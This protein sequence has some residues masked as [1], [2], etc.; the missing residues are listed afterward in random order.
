MTSA[1]EGGQPTVELTI[2]IQYPLPELLPEYA[3]LGIHST[4]QL[5]AHEI[6]EM[7]LDPSFLFELIDSRSSEVTFEA[8]VTDGV[9]PQLT[10]FEGEVWGR[11]DG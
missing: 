9:G 3:E 7:K 11:H 4:E 10:L 1:Q 5:L 2:R 6:E 8:D